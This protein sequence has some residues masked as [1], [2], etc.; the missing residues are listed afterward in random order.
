MG[1]KALGMGP[2]LALHTDSVKA[3]AATCVASAELER[4]GRGSVLGRFDHEAG[5]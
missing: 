1:Q 4:R 5:H 2:L 3:A